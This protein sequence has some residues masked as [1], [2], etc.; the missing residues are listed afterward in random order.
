MVMT[1]ES[2][3]DDFGCESVAEFSW[4]FGF[5][6]AGRQLSRSMTM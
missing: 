3:A 2:V 6:R 4:L 5:R 1:L